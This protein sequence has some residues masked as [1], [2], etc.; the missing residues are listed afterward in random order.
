MLKKMPG[1]LLTGGQSHLVTG[2]DGSSFAESDS[3]VVRLFG[4]S[5]SQCWSASKVDLDA[6]DDRQGGRK[7]AKFN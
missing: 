3:P 2:K 1:S 6:S 4:R 7:D 5:R